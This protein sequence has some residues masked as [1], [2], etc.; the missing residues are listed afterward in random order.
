MDHQKSMTS[1]ITVTELTASIKRI[2][3]PQGI[4]LMVRG[5]VVNYVKQGSG[6]IYFSLKDP[7][8]QISC[9]FFKGSQKNNIDVQSGDEVIIHGSL[10]V[11]AP[12]GSY[13][14]IVRKIEKTGIGDLLVELQKRKDEATKRGWLAQETKK[15]L[16]PY[17]K[18]IGIITSPTGAVIQDIIHVL[19][20]RAE[21]FNALLYPVRVQG[22]EAESEIAEAIQYMNQKKLCDVLVV[23]RGGG[24]LEDLLPFHSLLIAKEIFLSSIPVISAVGHESDYTLCD[25]VADVRAPTPSAAAELCMQEKHQLLKDLRK[26]G[27]SFIQHLKEQIGSKKLSLKYLSQHPFFSDP[28]SILTHYSQKNDEN[29]KHLRT[30]YTEQ[31]HRFKNWILEKN[32]VLSHHA[33]QALLQKQKTTFLQLK[34]RLEERRANLLSEKKQFCQ[35][36]KKQ[37]DAVHPLK[38]LKRG[39][40]ISF[41]KNSK[42]PI[43]SVNEL[44]LGDEV[45][46]TYWDGNRI[47][48]IK[49]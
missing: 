37:I 29:E 1:I 34:E 48:T 24:S 23:A 26:K 8:S 21:S 9:A 31:I 5:E 20:R 42:K 11:Y 40:C 7:S 2:L 22:K 14:I 44:N 43:L 38:V 3:E 17:P 6:H 32:I 28:P 41:Q 13:Q 25:Y 27:E 45:K 12:R 30:V 16:P 47:A 4:N 15:R 39:Y 18:T 35:Y 19:T 49:E 10:S 46:L 36:I 33:P